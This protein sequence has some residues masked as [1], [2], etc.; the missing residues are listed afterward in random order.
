[1]TDVDARR[2][3]AWAQGVDLSPI[4]TC[5]SYRGYL[6]IERPLPWPKDIGEAPALAG[7][8]GR[9]PGNQAPGARVHGAG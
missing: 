9:F 6:L 1:M 2:C 4:G 5:G 7:L 3:S 8:A